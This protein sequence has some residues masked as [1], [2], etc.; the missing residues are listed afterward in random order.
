[1]SKKIIMKLEGK[2]TIVT[3]GTQEMSLKVDGG[4]WMR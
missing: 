1:M 3:N 2:V 4:N